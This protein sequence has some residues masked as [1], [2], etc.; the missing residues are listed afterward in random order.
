MDDLNYGDILNANSRESVSNDSVKFDKSSAAQV[1]YLKSIDEKLEQLLKSAKNT[2]Q[3]AGRDR[4]SRDDERRYNE[5]TRNRSF[6]DQIPRKD[7]NYRRSSFS[8]NPIDDFLDSFEREIG[9]QLLD[10]V[11]DPEFKKKLQGSLSEFAKS[12]G[13]NISDL[14]DLF[15]KMLANNAATAFKNSKFGQDLIT[16]LKSVR[17]SVFDK[18]SQSQSANSHTNQHTSTNT[19]NSYTNSRSYRD[20]SNNRSTEYDRDTYREAS[21]SDVSSNVNSVAES[22]LSTLTDGV[23]NGVDDAV[24]NSGISNLLGSTTST[25]TATTGQVAGAG[26]SLATT[27]GQV[28]SQ[29]A[30]A[31]TSLAALGPYALAAVA[32]FMLVQKGLELLGPAIERTTQFLDTLDKVGNRMQ[33]SRQKRLEHA[34]QRA[35]DDIESIVREP[36]EIL[37]DAANKVYEVWDSQLRIINGT[38]GYNKSDFQDLLGS[39]ANRL[40]EEGLTDVISGVDITEALSSVLQSG[41]SGEVAEEFAYIATKLNAAIPTQDFFQY[42]ETYASLAANAMKSGK[43]QSEA[44]EYANEQLELFA[45][46]ILYASRQISGGFSTGLQNASD[47]FDAAVKIAVTS[48]TGNPAEIAGVLTAVSAATGAIA[49]DLA[50]SMTDAIISAAT[51]GNSSELVALRS[52]AGINA[53][54]TEFLRQLAEDPQSVFS[55]LFSNLAEMQN[56][57][58]GAYMEVAE[59]L[60]SIF[61]LSMD[62]FARID[63]NYLADAISSMDV[64]NSALNENMN[65][66]RS[67][68][69]TTSAEQLRMQQI[70]K[71]LV[72]EGLSYVLDNEVARSVQ[73]HMWN[74]QIANELM[75]AT[76]A[77]ELQGSALEFLEGI[78]TTIENILNF[79]NPFSWVGKLF[80]IGATANETIAQHKD[81]QQILELGKVGNGNAQSLYQLLTRGKQLKIV[82]DYVSLIGGHSYYGDA[83]DLTN[84]IGSITNPL[85][86]STFYMNPFYQ[87]LVGQS[88]VVSQSIQSGPSS[89]YSWA[90]V[91]KSMSNLLNSSSSSSVGVITTP[92]NT[93]SNSDKALSA[94]QANVDKMLEE[95]YIKSFVE[96]GKGYDDWAATSANFGI[97]NLDSAL[98]EIGYSKEQVKARFQSAQVDQGV[99]KQLERIAAEDEFWKNM[100]DYTVQLIDLTT[101]GNEILTNLLAKN[102][103]FYDAWVDYFIKHTAYSAAYDHTSVSDIQREEKAESE[104]AV[105]A[106]ADALTKNTVDLLDPTV[107]TNA[108]L[109]QILIV[110]NAIMQ[111]NN[112]A[113]SNTSSL[114]D[115]LSA[116]ALGLVK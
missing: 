102:T 92:V 45:S 74:E 87:A 27:M 67:G 114:P 93:E 14:P 60:S 62:A 89:K 4:V 13:G 15:G 22:A 94:L 46:N 80:T 107:Q 40:R 11:I 79:L 52:L 20:D 12:L 49:P 50:S 103:E 83:S 24:A 58:E 75:E 99:T 69:T 96:A 84:I 10:S 95:D 6:R 77:V 55:T 3:S 88:G 2:S 1:E 5:Y 66:L 32:A 54:N 98:E 81:L 90:N 39:Y 8:G 101:I 28:G 105:Y 91:S 111:Q 68:E 71:Y 44:I 63:F 78:R 34:Q 31:G 21:P 43:S 57:S 53:S 7:K 109:S 26:T 64:S 100:Q 38:Q 115:T 9:K 113:L 85:G 41:L 29:A 86:D 19:S 37:S 70:N 30:A 110:V 23:F 116:L 18:F 59:G 112:K 61:G 82:P 73:E 97:S 47:L 16:K 104:S 106:L 17:D 108:I 42:S 25:L 48:R 35:L 56:M 65:L 76:Y 72:E 51:G 33:Q 36:F